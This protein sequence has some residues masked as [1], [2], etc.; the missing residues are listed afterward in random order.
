MSAQ[1]Q[2]ALFLGHGDPQIAIHDDELTQ[3][4]SR[5]GERIVE[6]CGAPR[7]IL[8]MSAHWYTRGLFVQSAAKPRQ[9]HDMY[10]FPQELYDV[11]YP[12]LGDAELTEAVCSALG[13]DVSINDD[14]GIDHGT[15]T[16]L[17]HMFPQADIPVVQIS[18]NAL[19]GMGDAYELGKRL[20]FLRD[21][22]FMIAGSGNVV[23][24]LMAVDWSNPNGTPEADFFDTEI[25][26]AVR[27]RDDRMVLDYQQLAGADFA[28]PTPEH[29]A[30]LP[31]VLGASVGEVP[32]V[33]NEMRQY[34]GIS[35]TSFAFGLA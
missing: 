13:S 19:A 7:G 6:V 22:G 20:A 1:K 5:M 8:M 2:P 35:M 10:G 31:F 25:A 21:Q 16:V 9:V 29:F 34:A 17:V 33:F 24:N 11:T 26:R 30:P 28:V 23:H 15:W 18:T 27:N 12:V 32:V 3:S 14:W 4:L